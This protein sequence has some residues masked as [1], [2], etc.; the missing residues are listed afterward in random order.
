MR[1]RERLTV[2]PRFEDIKIVA[3][4]KKSHW[5]SVTQSNCS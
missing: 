5:D 4:G 2:N 1:M 3:V